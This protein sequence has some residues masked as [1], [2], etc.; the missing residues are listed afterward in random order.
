MTQTP[1]SDLTSPVAFWM[2]LWQIQLEQSLV[3][4]NAWAS[5]L[6]AE[7]AR[8]LAAEAEAMKA[9]DTPKPVRRARKAAG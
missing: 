2:K 8:E 7:S 6:P 5:L 9:E 4:W 1:K 3:F